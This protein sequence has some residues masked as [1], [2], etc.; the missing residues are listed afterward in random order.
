MFLM[1]RPK[2]YLDTSVISYLD[3]TDSPEKRADTLK[4]WA[5]LKMGAGKID[6]LVSEVTMREIERNREPKLSK[7]KSFLSEIE[8]QIVEETDEIK[9]VAQMFIKANLLTEKSYDDCVHIASSLVHDCTCIVSWNFKH[10][11]NIKMVNG[12]KLIA[13]QTGYGVA[14]FICNPSYFVEGI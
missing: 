9:K 1:R 8:Y 10:I 3:Q 4:F 12:V 6:I 11:V 5:Y 7:L 13:A 14:T 2:I